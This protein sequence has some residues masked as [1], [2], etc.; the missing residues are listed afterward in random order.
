LEELRKKIVSWIADIEKFQ[1]DFA[2]DC[3]YALIFFPLERRKN[4]SGAHS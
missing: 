4:F 1:S 3:D 2:F